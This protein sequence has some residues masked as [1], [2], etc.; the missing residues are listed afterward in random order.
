MTARPSPSRAPVLALAAAGIAAAVLRILAHVDL[1]AD[2]AIAQP[3]LDGRWSIETA[4]R[5][6]AQGG[7]GST[8]FFMAPLYPHLLLPFAAAG[9][10]PV[11]GMRW[12]Q[13]VLGLATWG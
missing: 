11:S 8:P 6:L 12:A 7:W 2:P 5:W 3:I 10:D 1:G 4:A 13:L 9:L